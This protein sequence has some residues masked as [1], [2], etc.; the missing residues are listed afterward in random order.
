LIA[1][2][3]E[4]DP[5]KLADMMTDAAERLLEATADRPGDQTTPWHA[6]FP[7]ELAGL[8]CIILGEQILHG[9]DMAIAADRPWPIDPDH[10]KLVLYGYGPG[11]SLLVN[12]ATTAHL[13][14]GYQIQL[15]G[16]DAFTIRFTDGVYSPEPAGTG[17][18]DATIT[19]DPVAF[20][21]VVSG[22]LPQHAALAL[23]LL[24]TAGDHPDQALGFKDLF[25]YP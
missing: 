19:A 13:T 10:A 20:L 25:I 23:G 2:I 15:R 9:Y 5:D 3:P 8:V 7:L 21:L 14:A 22:R 16:G 24:T 17:P 18:V 11:Y 6:G 12:P 4:T 1:D